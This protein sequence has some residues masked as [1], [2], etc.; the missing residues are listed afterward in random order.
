MTEACSLYNKSDGLI[1]LRTPSRPQ[2]SERAF[3]FDHP[4][5]STAALPESP[6][7]PAHLSGDERHA[8]PTAFENAEGYGR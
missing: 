7:L 4:T 3:A 6:P 2:P 5:G 8:F 1:W